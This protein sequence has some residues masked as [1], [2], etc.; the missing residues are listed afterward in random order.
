MG[1]TLSPRIGDLP[2]NWR[3]GELANWRVGELASWRVGELAK[4][5]A[6]W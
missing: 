3:I 5:L 4:E 6:N 1:T 2:K